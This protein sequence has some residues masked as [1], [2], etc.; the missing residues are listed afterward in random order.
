MDSYIKGVNELIQ[1]T[2]GPPG[3]LGVDKHVESLLNQDVGLKSIGISAFEHE[4]RKKKSPNYYHDK[5]T[6]AYHNPAM[7]LLS[8]S[9]S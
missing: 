6:I 1:N 3:H 8:S 9:E 7:S 2:F 4:T 5:D